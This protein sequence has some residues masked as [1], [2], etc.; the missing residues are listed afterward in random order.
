[1][2]EFSGGLVKLRE[3]F[4]ASQP[5]KAKE[6]ADASYSVNVKKPVKAK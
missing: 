5:L 2:H 6:S 3:P 1:M 4:D